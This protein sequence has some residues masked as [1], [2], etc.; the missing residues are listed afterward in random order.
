MID[1]NA[2]PTLAAFVPGYLHQDFD[3]CGGVEG[4]LAAWRAD[5]SAGAVDDLAREWRI[6]LSATE[7]LDVETRGQLLEEA[8]GGAW[9]PRSDTELHALTRALHPRDEAADTFEA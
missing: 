5:T 8:F 3:V 7:G 6:F 4:A 1:P 9:A 2:F